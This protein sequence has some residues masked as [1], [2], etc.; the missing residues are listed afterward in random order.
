LVIEENDSTQLRYFSEI[1]VVI[2]LSTE[3]SGMFSGMFSEM[4]TIEKIRQ[5][6]L[7]TQ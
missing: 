7:N 4:L 1:I 2:H 6:V 5:T 3:S